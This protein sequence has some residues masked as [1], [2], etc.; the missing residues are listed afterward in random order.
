M[1]EYYCRIEYYNIKTYILWIIEFFV[2]FYSLRLVHECL[3]G[4]YSVITGGTFGHIGVG[5]WIFF[6]P[7]FYITCSGGNTFAVVEGTL[8]TTWLIALLLVILT[9][10][11]FLRL[12]MDSCR[13]LNLSGKLFGIQ[14]GAA[15]EMIGEGIYAL[16]NFVLID[17]F[18]QKIYPGDGTVMYW[19]FQNM[20]YNPL[21]QYFIAFLMIFGGICVV[22]WVL[23]CHEIFCSRCSLV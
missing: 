20:G 6:V 19:W 14:L 4:I 17:L 11:N 9:S 15:V 23:K 1:G 8:L 3:H 13:A 16:P 21:T 2:T 12:F 18:G 10:F 7:V 22:F 5:Q